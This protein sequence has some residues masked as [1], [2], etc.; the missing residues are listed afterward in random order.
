MNPVRVIGIAGFGAL[1]AQPGCVAAPVRYVSTP[2]PTAQALS[3]LGDTLWNLPLDPEDGQRRIRLLFKAR[4]EVANRPHDINAK[5]LLARRTVGVGRLRE[6]VGIYTEAIGQDPIDLRLPRRRGEVLLQIRELNLA[7]ADLTRAARGALEGGTELEYNDL[8]DGSGFSET[9]L[10]HSSLF[11]LAMAFYLKGDFIQARDIHL[12]ALKRARNA[13]EVAK[14]VLWLFFATRRLGQQAEAAE[15]L[16]KINLDM[17]VSIAAPEHQLLLA[18]RGD[19]PEDSL[20]VN[21][22]APLKTDADAMFGYGIGFALLMQGREEEAGLAF[23]HVR[24]TPNWAALSFLAAE[25]ELARMR[26]SKP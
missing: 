3:L 20:P 23:Q 18:F 19:L 26:R 15:I 8:P 25:A 2:P 21:F 14:T 13:D 11:Y 16:G 1:L 9:T 6:A 4:D 24:A 17:P 10:Q 7:V 22:R 5:I 12:Q